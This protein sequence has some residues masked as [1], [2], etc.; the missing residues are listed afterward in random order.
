MRDLYILSFTKTGEQTACRIAESLHGVSGRSVHA[1]RIRSLGN[2]VTPIF[3]RENGLVFVGA[4]GIAV[5][6]VASLLK[7]KSTDPP[8][9]VVD[10]LGRF[11]IPILSGHL[12][13][14]NR[15]AEEIALKIGATPVLT[16]AT[17]IRGVFAVDVFASE[18]G[19]SILDPEKIVAVSA[20]LLEG[21]T[22]GLA[23]DM[24]ISG[25]L[26]ENVV[27]GDEGEVGICI[28]VELEK[29][30]FKKTLHL[31]PKCFHVG[32][33]CKRGISVLDLNAFLSDVLAAGRI[34]VEAVGSFSS[35][36]LK[37]DEEAIVM[38]AER[39]RVPFRVYSREELAAFESLFATSDFV[40]KTTGTGNVCE[41]S[42]WLS[43]KKGDMAVK[44]TVRS[45]MTL[46]V[47][48]QSWTIRFAQNVHCREEVPEKE[49]DE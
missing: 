40:R 29:N 41:I 17:D 5:R 34:P 35:I 30:P 16:T 1:E 4:A 7:S 38:L 10:E 24:E 33:G 2:S 6:A 47:A 31:V 26:P 36:A 28:G 44:K 8:V 25:D 45:G 3:R 13:G 11:V 42:A 48:R 32:I 46:A 12:G 21:K 49:A 39:H 18:N 22:V 27:R 20:R 14:A 9:I 23:T 37:R 43:A 15:L 19:Y